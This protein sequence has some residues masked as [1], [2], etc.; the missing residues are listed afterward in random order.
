MLWSRLALGLLFLTPCLSTLVADTLAREPDRVLDLW[1][2][3]APGEQTREIG[4]PQ[5]QRASEKPP[6]TRI[7]GITQPQIM[8]FSPPQPSG[9]G[10]AV[11][12]FPG[13][14]YNYVV[15]DKEG[16]EV[17]EWLNQL[18]V[19]AFVVRYRT[20]L[21]G[22]PGGEAWQRP[23]QDGQRAVRL[24]RSQA[25][26]L[27]IDPTKIGVLGFSAGG[28]AAALVAT[29]FEKPAYTETDAVDRISCRPD[30]CMLVYPAYLVDTKSGLLSDL[31]TVTKQTPP[32][33]L[34]HAHDDSVTSLSSVQ[35]YI[36]LKHNG[37][38]AELHIYQ[39]GG[40]GYGARPV[41]NSDVA[42]WN[43]RAA[44]WLERRELAKRS[45]VE[46]P[47]K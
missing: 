31:V 40:H 30:F 2:D 25:D 12:I 4:H 14:G 43:Q 34:A 5:P 16:S 33:F 1:P 21:P 22:Q 6:A 7:G 9:S 29:R 13:G 38:P 19:T 41:A 10:A 11:L 18:G 28:Q 32:S 42:S 44:D 45:Q 35:F 39:N 8:M 37:V 20:K 3:S 27:K 36:A 17:A 46:A 47:H 15:V 26:Q 23:L 24:V